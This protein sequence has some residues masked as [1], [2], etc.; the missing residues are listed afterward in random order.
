MA[1]GVSDSH[2]F[3]PEHCIDSNLATVCRPSGLGNPAN[4]ILLDLLG[5]I[6]VKSITIY[7]PQ[8]NVEGYDPIGH[9]ITVDSE[10]HQ[11][12]ECCPNSRFIV[13]TL[14]FG[15]FNKGAQNK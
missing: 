14:D 3:S 2:L 8:T 10:H 1:P 11:N 13:R 9:N 6:S 15:V 7:T 4:A 12:C 5:Q